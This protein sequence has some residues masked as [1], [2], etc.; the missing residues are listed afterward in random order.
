MKINGLP[1]VDAKTPI[2]LSINANDIKKGDGGDPDACAAAVACMRQLDCRAAKVHM[3][4]IYILNGKK[5]FRYSTPASIRSE[6]IAFD[7]R[8]SFKPGIYKLNPP[9]HSDVVARGKQK[10]SKTNQTRAKAATRKFKRA[11]PHF[12][13]GVRGR[14]ADFKTK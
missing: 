12:V 2:M 13:E 8:N 1:V 5:W 11:T 7:R 10:G 9:F 6:I 14:M 3:G 4:R